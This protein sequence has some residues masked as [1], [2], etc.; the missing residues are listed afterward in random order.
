MKLQCV[1]LAGGLAT[2]LKP[3]T[4]KI[5]K[6]MLKIKDTPF[7]EYQIELLG[8]NNIDEIIVCVG[9]LSEQIES[10]F[11]NGERFGVNIKYS[12]EKD[13]LLGTGGAIRNAWSLLQNNFFV[14]Y[15]DSYLNINYGAVYRYF[16]KINYSSL[17]V[18]YKNKNKWDKSNV[19]FKSGVVELYDKK[20]Q[21]PEIKYIDYGLSILS[22]KVIKE[23][24][25][26][27]FYDLANLY[28]RLAREKKLAGYEVFRRFYE[29]GSKRGLKE[30]KDFMER[31]GG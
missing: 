13:Q 6:S 14:I 16:L 4:E 5:P 31:E 23:V 2:R 12:Y 11:G 28:K 3:I 18:I 19:V 29:I 15:G 1:I 27:V 24:P 17:L 30:F 22:K 21:T 20:S 7:L 9:Y 8:K 26:G 10:Y 25:E